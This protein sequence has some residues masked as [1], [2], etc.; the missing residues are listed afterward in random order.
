VKDGQ[1]LADLG[2]PVLYSGWKFGNALMQLLAGD[3]VQPETELVTR[4]FTAENV[5]GLTLTPEAYLSPDWFGDDSY[6]QI[7]KAAWGV[8]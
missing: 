3:T 7:F 5:G 8:A 4:H 6:V 2:T 1:Q